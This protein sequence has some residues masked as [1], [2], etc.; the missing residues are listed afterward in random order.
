[1][2]REKIRKKKLEEREKKEVVEKGEKKEDEIR[3][4]NISWGSVPEPAGR[5]HPVPRAKSWD[6]CSAA[7]PTFAPDNG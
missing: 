4:L 7:L 1:M 2:A 3:N 6:I 5:T